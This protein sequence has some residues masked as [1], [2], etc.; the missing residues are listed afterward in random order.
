[1]SDY[2]GTNFPVL[3]VEVIGQ[4]MT[5]YWVEAPDIVRA[6][7]PGQFVIVRLDEDGERIPLTV[8]DWSEDTGA[9]RLRKSAGRPPRWPS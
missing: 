1:M 5:S 6:L 4:D 3:S 9:L 7:G 2:L 8:V